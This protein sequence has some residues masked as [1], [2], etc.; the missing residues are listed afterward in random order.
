MKPCLGGHVSSK[1]GCLFIEHSGQPSGAVPSPCR[2]GFQLEG[3]ETQGGKLDPYIA[4]PTPPIYQPPHPQISQRWLTYK[5]TN[6]TVFT[7]TCLQSEL[8]SD[9]SVVSVCFVVWISFQ[10]GC[11]DWRWSSLFWGF[12]FGGGRAGEICGTNMHTG[13]HYTC[14]HNLPI[15]QGLI[16]KRD[17]NAVHLHPHNIFLLLLSDLLFFL[18]VLSKAKGHIYTFPFTRRSALS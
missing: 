6:C 1:L 3:T 8:R 9:I 18:F 16:V 7:D 2:G 11:S 4:N 17:I 12:F 14:Y 15:C 10:R 5:R 13:I